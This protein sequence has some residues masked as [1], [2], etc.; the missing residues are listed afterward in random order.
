MGLTASHRQKERFA[1]HITDRDKVASIREGGLKGS[2]TTNA[3]TDL[4]AEALTTEGYDSPFPFDR[5]QVVYCHVNP[6]AVDWA[7]KSSTEFANTPAVVVVDLSKV[8]DPLY[9]ASMTIANDFIDHHVAP[10]GNTATESLD[11]A[12]RKYND[13][14][15]QLSDIDSI[16]QHR[17]EFTDHIELIV[18]GDVPTEAIV[19]T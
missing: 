4:I 15:V 7:R 12:V 10:A 11:E 5:T 13:S 1:F 17:D 16:S 8:L 18:D 6:A 2:N 9:I 19:E 3:D 14:I